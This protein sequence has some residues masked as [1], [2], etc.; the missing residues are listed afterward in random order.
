MQVIKDP[1]SGYYR[2]IGRVESAWIGFED[3]GI[4]T[5]GLDVNYGGGLHQ[6]VGG[7]FL[8][9]RDASGSEERGEAKPWAGDCI[10]R[11]L[12]CFGVDKIHQIAGRTAYFLW[13]DDKTHNVLPI[14]IEPLPVSNGERFLFADVNRGFGPA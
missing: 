2:A 6:G 9:T 4:L 13:K 8:G 11:L 5:F 12:R 14:G 7:L 3:H 1:E 10:I